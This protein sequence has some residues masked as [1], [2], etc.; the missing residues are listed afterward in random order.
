MLPE[1]LVAG[2]LVASPPSA[3]YGPPP[4]HPFWSEIVSRAGLQPLATHRALRLVRVSLALLSA[5]VVTVVP[6]S[7][8]A[9]VDVRILQ[10]RRKAGAEV[11]SRELSQERYDT[12]R[13][14]AKAGLWSKR[15]TAP[16]GRPELTDGVL[17]Y[18]EGF[19]EGERYA[20]VRHEP[21]DPEV[22]ALCNE[23]MSIVGTPEQGPRP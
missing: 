17:W 18:L 7:T 13:A 4:E 8:G 9:H 20:I 22:A 11:S 16:T 3:Y 1:L 15:A 14:L 21:S 10:D 19:R 6:T 5:T 2:W 12:L 23:F